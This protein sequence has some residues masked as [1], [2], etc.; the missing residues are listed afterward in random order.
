MIALKKFFI[1]LFLLILSFSVVFLCIEFFLKYHYPQDLSGS[2]RIRN[3]SGLITNKNKG[4]SKHSWGGGELNVRYSFG[5]YHNRI[6][7][8][9]LVDYPNEKI[10]ILGDSFTFGWLLNDEDTFIYQLQEKFNN[11]LF[12]NAAAGGWGTADHLKY[13]ELYCKKINPKEVWVFLNNDD[14]QRSINSN[15]YKIDNNDELIK[16]NPQVN[17][18]QKIKFFLNSFFLYQW[19]LENFHSIQLIRN[20]LIKIPDSNI[21]FSKIKNSTHDSNFLAKK[22]FIELK[23]ETKFCNSDLKIFY[24]GWPEWHNDNKILNFIKLANKENFFYNNNINFFNL[25]YTNYMIDI[26][27]NENFYK[28]K[29]GHPNKLGNKKIFFAILS[30]LK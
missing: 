14:I 11:T 4:E 29:E 30:I 7:Q 5:E 25:G 18:N 23:K 22:L 19:L 10:L 20:V 9:L 13:T 28:L 16:L 2:W 17:I 21:T 6:Y 26:N 27:K 15:L 24:L 3:E 12:I 8:N 1:N